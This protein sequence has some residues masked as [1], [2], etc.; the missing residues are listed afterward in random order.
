M[1]LPAHSLVDRPDLRA[2]AQPER[3]GELGAAVGVDRGSFAGA[4]DGDIGGRCIDGVGAE[5]LQM[6][7]DVIARRATVFCQQVA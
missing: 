4:G 2:I 5:T 6:R 3:L 7:H 1:V